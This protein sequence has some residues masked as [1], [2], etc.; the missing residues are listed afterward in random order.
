MNDVVETNC[1]NTNFTIT[2]D[3]FG[4][5]VQKTTFRDFELKLCLLDTNQSRPDG[6]HICDGSGFLVRTYLSAV[7]SFHAKFTQRTN[8]QTTGSRKELC[9]SERLSF[10]SRQSARLVGIR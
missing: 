4:E 6:E 3:C 1:F 7:V 10:L 2:F 9:S 5:L 8:I